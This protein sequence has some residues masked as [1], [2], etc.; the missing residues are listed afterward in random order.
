MKDDLIY[1]LNEEDAQT[2]AIEVLDR[3]LNSVEMSALKDKVAEKIAWFDAISDALTD[4]ISP[5]EFSP[6]DW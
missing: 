2:V 1:F 5:D 6:D 3:E 4:I